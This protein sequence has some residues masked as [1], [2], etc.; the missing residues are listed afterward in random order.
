MP[1]RILTRSANINHSLFLSAKHSSQNAEFEVHP[2]LLWLVPKDR[3]K[4]IL[5]RLL[6]CRVKNELENSTTTH[7]TKAALL[8]SESKHVLSAA[9]QPE[10]TVSDTG[11][12]SPPSHRP[13]TQHSSGL[14]SRR[15]RTDLIHTCTRTE[16]PHNPDVITNS[17]WPFLV[18]A[19]PHALVHM[20]STDAVH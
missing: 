15:G 7:I 19:G 10:D 6:C 3:V 18:A 2:G 8:Y 13:S 20:G 1:G 16:A 11:P 5:P 17:H 4:D 12:H 14:E 9:M